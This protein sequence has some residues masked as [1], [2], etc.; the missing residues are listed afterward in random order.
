MAI[1]IRKTGSGITEKIEVWTDEPV[2]DITFSE[3]VVAIRQHAI[4]EA[5]KG[6]YLEVCRLLVEQCEKAVEAIAAG[7]LEA[8]G[9]LAFELGELCEQ[10][11]IKCGW[12]DHALRGKKIITAA[13]SGGQARR[14]KNDVRDR[15]MAEEFQRRARQSNKSMTAL[16]EEIGKSHG[17]RRSASVAAIERGLKILSG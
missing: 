5:K 3:K 14:G 11:V 4:E 15:E 2:E 1:S 7:D 10:L 6:K 17:L 8:A 13:A 16:K 12:E 9:W